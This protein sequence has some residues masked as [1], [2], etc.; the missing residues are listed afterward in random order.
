[1]ARSYHPL[2]DLI[3]ETPSAIKAKYLELYEA[4]RTSGLDVEIFTEPVALG[5]AIFG[6]IAIAGTAG[7]VAIGAAIVG[8]VVYNMYQ[9]AKTLR[10]IA[11]I[12]EKYGAP[13]KEGIDWTIP[14][15]VSHA[16]KRI[17]GKNDEQSKL[18]KS[19][20]EVVTPKKVAMSPPNAPPV[21]PKKEE[22][23]PAEAKPAKVELL[24]PKFEPIEFPTHSPK[25]DGK[26][27][28]YQNRQTGQTD[29]IDRGEKVDFTNWKDPV[30]LEAAL[31]LT[32]EKWG[33][34]G[35]KLSGSDEF[36]G[37][38]IAHAA[39][40]GIADR[41]TNPELQ[42][43]IALAKKAVPEALKNGA[44]PEEL[45]APKRSTSMALDL[46]ALHKLAPV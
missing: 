27:V 37:A 25:V 17:T 11:E 14:G 39:R 24:A 19:A 33:K 31:R 18:S 12:K 16:W 9:E 7:V 30:A 44:V 40:L 29:F 23:K 38:A 28:H 4:N 5:A 15:L 45:K 20:E 1:M 6:G 2:N 13:V 3:P 8:K 41:I 10:Q 43:S 46:G 35:F 21:A 36:L 26:I 22:P 32:A 34:N 42:D